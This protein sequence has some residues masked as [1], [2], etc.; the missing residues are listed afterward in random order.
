MNTN[1][2]MLNELLKKY[3]PSQRGMLS[4]EEYSLVKETLC[5]EEMDILQLR[6]LR[7]F[8]VAFFSNQEKDTMENWDKMSAIT[9]VI[10]SHIVER[11]GEV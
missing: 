3:K 7:D 1:H 11:G 10:E 8:T 2:W 9:C 4:S 6:N 5:L